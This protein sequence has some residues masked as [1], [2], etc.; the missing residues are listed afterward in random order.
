MGSDIVNTVSVVASKGHRLCL[1]CSRVFIPAAYGKRGL[2]KARYCLDCRRERLVPNALLAR[3]SAGKKHK[4]K[5]PDPFAPRY[6][7][8]EDPGQKSWRQRECPD[9]SRIFETPRAQRGKYCPE[10]LLRRRQAN[11]T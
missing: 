9:C 8:P 7:A 10:C 5:P 1:D 6:L 11:A 2:S 4:P 3:K